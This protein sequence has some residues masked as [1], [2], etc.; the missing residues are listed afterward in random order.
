MYS[1]YIHVEVLKGLASLLILFSSVYVWFVSY[2]PV[3]IVRV[4]RKIFFY[5]R[6]FFVVAIYSHTLYIKVFL[7]F[8]FFLRQTMVYKL[9][10][11]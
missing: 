11:F 6:V 1:V 8:Y 7:G 3:W 9:N 2:L 5:Q 10:N 4:Q